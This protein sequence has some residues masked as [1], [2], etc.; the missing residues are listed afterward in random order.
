L[1]KS[2]TVTL[3]ELETFWSLDDV[4]RMNTILDISEEIERLTI[5]G[6]QQQHE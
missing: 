6:M 5:E 3:Q 2:G 4:I 1:V